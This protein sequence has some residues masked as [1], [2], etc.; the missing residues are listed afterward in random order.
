MRRNKRLS[1]FARFKGE[2]NDTSGARNK[3]AKL[4]DGDVADIR[5]RCLEQGEVQ[6]EVARLYRVPRGTVHDIVTGQ[7]RAS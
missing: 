4:S 6:A 2:A 5:R 7:R 3:R 1:D